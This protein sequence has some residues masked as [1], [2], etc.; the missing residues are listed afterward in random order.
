[1]TIRQLTYF[2]T[3]YK[4]G[5][6]LK[7]AEELYISQQALSR[8]LSLLETELGAPLFTRSHKGVAPTPAETELFRGAQPVLQAM[9]ALESHMNEFIQLGNGQLRIGLAAATR[10]L[11]GRSIWQN[12]QKKY[13]QITLQ[14]KEYPS[15]EGLRLLESNQLDVLT[16]SDYDAGEDYNQYPLKSWDRVLLVPRKHPLYDK[17][18][19][20][21]GDL[22]GEHIA[23][24][25]NPMIYR[26][27]QDFIRE[28]DFPPTD[29]T[30]VSDTLYMYETC[31]SDQC[32]G[33][34]IQGCFSDVFL[35]QFPDLK[36]LP[37]REPF[38]PY[39]VTAISKKGHPMAPVIADLADYLSK[40]L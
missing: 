3:I 30:L 38:F 14:V 29:I 8:A 6:L 13:P 5:N 9:S 37:F 40:Q 33:I 35:P 15:L 26:Q 10:Y 27:I 17:D 1:M 31:H 39:T 28:N 20:E 7:A 2:V 23:F 36:A 18:Y 19:A 24:C 25:A 22:A 16:F 4:R 11:T 12:F 34:A 21:P 32:L